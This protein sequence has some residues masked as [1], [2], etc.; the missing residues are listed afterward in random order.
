MARAAFFLS[1][2]SGGYAGCGNL[3]ARS[4]MRERR[5]HAAA[6]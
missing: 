2:S 5:A 1:V 3:R 4:Q 6:D